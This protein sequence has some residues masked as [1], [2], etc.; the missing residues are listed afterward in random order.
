MLRNAMFRNAVIF[1]LL[2]CFGSAS[3]ADE[4]TQKTIE[5]RQGLLKVVAQYFGPIVGMAKGQIPYEAAL[6]EKN[7]GM[8]AQLA[9]MIP[10]MFAMDTSASDIASQSKADIWGDYADFIAKAA[11]TAERAEALVAATTEG[12]GATMKAFGALGASCKSCHDSYRQK[13]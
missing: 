1:S 9:P 7:A 8:I 5:A 4:R 13:N 11:T 12:R 2:L 3:W 10:D 6:I